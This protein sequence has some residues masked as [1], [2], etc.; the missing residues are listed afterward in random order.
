MENTICIVHLHL[1]KHHYLSITPF[2]FSIA[3]NTSVNIEG[4]IVL[5]LSWSLLLS[6][7]LTKSLPA[8][9]VV[10]FFFIS[11]SSGGGGGMMSLRS[12]ACGMGLPQRTLSLRYSHQSV[13]FPVGSRFCEAVPVNVSLQLKLQ[14]ASANSS[15]FWTFPRRGQEGGIKP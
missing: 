3:K 15:L 11:C 4:S 5:R 8:Q 10:F 1:H 14:T 2:R 6:T 13:T 7:D 12:F 9:L